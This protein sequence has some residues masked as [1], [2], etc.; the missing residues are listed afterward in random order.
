MVVGATSNFEGTR[1]A[2]PSQGLS[3]QSFDSYPAKKGKW[4]TDEMEDG[5]FEPHPK[6]AFRTKKGLLIQGRSSG[7]KPSI[8]IPLNPKGAESRLTHLREHRLRFMIRSSHRGGVRVIMKNRHRIEAKLPWQGFDSSPSEVMKE[9]NPDAFLT[10]TWAGKWQHLEM[11]VFRQNVKIEGEVSKLE[12]KDRWVPH[13]LEFRFPSSMGELELHLDEV[14]MDIGSMVSP[15]SRGMMEMPLQNI[16]PSPK[17]P[18]P[19]WTFSPWESWCP[20]PQRWPGEEDVKSGPSASGGWELVFSSAKSVLSGNGV[21]EIR[22]SH[23]IQIGVGQGV[24]RLHMS[25]F[26]S[27][28]VD[29]RL[30]LTFR[31]E[32]VRT[33]KKLSKNPRE[34]HEYFSTHL[35]LDFRGRRGFDIPLNFIGLPHRSE[36]RLHNKK[37]DGY[38]ELVSME[39]VPLGKVDSAEPFRHRLVFWPLTQW[40]EKELWE[41]NYPKW[42]PGEDGHPDLP[43]R[44]RI[45]ERGVVIRD[46]ESVCWNAK[47]WKGRETETPILT[48]EEKSAH[49]GQLGLQVIVPRKKRGKVGSVETKIYFN[50]TKRSPFDQKGLGEHQLEI[51]FRAS[52]RGKARLL[53]KDDS[54]VVWSSPPELFR[55]ESSLEKPFLSESRLVFAPFKGKARNYIDEEGRRGYLAERPMGIY[56][57]HVELSGVKEEARVDLDDLTLYHPPSRTSLRPLGMNR[58]ENISMKESIG[59]NVIFSPW[60]S[61]VDGWFLKG[62]MTRDLEAEGRRKVLEAQY[63]EA[64]QIYEKLRELDRDSKKDFSDFFDDR[65]RLPQKGEDP[66]V[67]GMKV[68]TQGFWLSLEW[69]EEKLP[70]KWLDWGVQGIELS[71]VTPFPWIDRALPLGHGIV[72]LELDWESSGF[73]GSFWEV[74]LQDDEGHIFRHRVSLEEK[75]AFSL[76][77]GFNSSSFEIENDK[78]E[79]CFLSR[80][81][82]NLR[83]KK[84]WVGM[85]TQKEKHTGRQTLRLGVPRLIVDPKADTRFR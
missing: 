10:H 18:V 78:G 62:P 50:Q 1:L 33:T 26:S 9:I 23:P 69:Q 19:G 32:K 47:T 16:W 60:F 66:I 2:L 64:M 31:E 25:L 30:R 42:S 7:I 70:A 76:G 68:D 74:S 48:A 29:H 79:A 24:R 49:G 51:Q 44:T 34:R 4:Y 58:W 39:L 40:V 3:L 63:K 81:S 6:A 52:H 82:G 59:G 43:T 55:A 56:G 38:L 75:G 15:L 53:L 65:Q 67:H 14:V 54:G 12:W 20:K 72:G 35:P 77:L 8:I 22:P 46:M 80:P 21:L 45:G 57:L 83:L 85:E 5:R 17:F 84:V 28:V 73:L 61:S 71:R 36:H 11:P 27:G 41:K 37:I 13:A